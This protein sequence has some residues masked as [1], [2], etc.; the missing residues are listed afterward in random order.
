MPLDWLSMAINKFK[1]LSIDL[2][3]HE[4]WSPDQSAVSAS[5]IRPYVWAVYRTASIRWRTSFQSMT[6]DTAVVG[7]GREGKWG[8][9]KELHYSRQIAVKKRAKRGVGGIRRW[10]FMLLFVQYSA[11]QRSDRGTIH[12]WPYLWGAFKQRRPMAKT[13]AVKLDYIYNVLCDIAVHGNWLRPIA[14]GLRHTNL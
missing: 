2:L 7:R 12:L 13:A 11:R 9:H 8:Y 10:K 4:K 5:H 6:N 1:L 3:P 14:N